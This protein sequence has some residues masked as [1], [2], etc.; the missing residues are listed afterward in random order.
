QVVSNL[1]SNAIKFTPKGGRVDVTLDADGGHA[2]V[3]VCDTG[4]GIAAG[5]LPHVFERFRQAGGALPRRAGGLGVGLTI[6]RQLVDMHGG[7]ITASSAGE[8]QGASF[9]GLLP[10]PG[11]AR[12]PAPLAA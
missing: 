4:C 6:A 7:T 2:V 11:D 3:R 9:T 1:I 12:T 8:G 5:F 10:R